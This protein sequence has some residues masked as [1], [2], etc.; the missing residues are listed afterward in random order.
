MKKLILFSFAFP[1]INVVSAQQISNQF[2]DVIYGLTTIINVFPSQYEKAQGTAFFFHEYKFDSLLKFNNPIDSNLKKIWLVTNSHV[3]FGDDFKNDPIYP[4]AVQFYLRKRITAGK[5][6]I[7][8]TITIY[9]NDVMRLVRKHISA[10]LSAIDITEFIKSKVQNDSNY[11]YNAIS[12]VN[13]PEEKFG[14]NGNNEYDL[15][16]GQE[17]ISVGYPK[18]FYDNFNLYPT[19]KSGMIASKWK[20][21]YR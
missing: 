13:F 14:I 17:I 1:F 5:Q 20:L 9:K 12:K 11:I 19:V 6:L 10:D 18:E 4:L 16:V 21:N 8:D 15:R 2:E 7:W 3:L